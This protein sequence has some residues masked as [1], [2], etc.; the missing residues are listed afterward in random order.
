VSKISNLLTIEL[1]CCENSLR[2]LEV[3]G[4]C[5]YEARQQFMKRILINLLLAGTFWVPVGSQAQT[6]AP[7]AVVRPGEKP[8]DATR[9]TNNTSDT[10]PELN[11]FDL[12]FP[13]GTPADLVA[14]IQQAN[15]RPLNAIIPDEYA[16]IHIPALRMSKVTVPELFEAVGMASQKIV[17]NVTGTYFAGNGKESVQYQQTRVAYGFKTVGIPREDSIW[18]FFNEVPP[19][20][21]GG[22]DDNQKGTVCRFFQLAPYLET[23]NIDDITTALETGWKMLDQGTIPKLSFHKDTKL[24]IAVGEP[25]KLRMI[26]EVLAQLRSNDGSVRTAE[27]KETTPAKSGEPKKP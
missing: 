24:L 14:A 9:V 6:V 18:Y 13:G 15:D 16:D 22:H 27:K 21:P 26:D 12:N 19:K 25:E 4:V 2:D 11:R 5:L 17:N 8:K 3:S 7:P 23:Y 1:T 10:K 20:P